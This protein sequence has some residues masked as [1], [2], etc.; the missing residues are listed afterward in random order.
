[1]DD[2][3]YER[4]SRQEQGYVVCAS[5]A[6]ATCFFAGLP[7]I[8]FGVVPR[9][10]TISLSGK[11]CTPTFS[12]SEADNS[13]SVGLLIP[14]TVARNVPTPSSCTLQDKARS[15]WSS[16]DKASSTF[17]T[18]P[19]LRLVRC[20]MARANSSVSMTPAYCTAGKQSS[21]CASVLRLRPLRGTMC[22]FDMQYLHGIYGH[23]GYRQSSLVTTS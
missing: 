5:S 12:T 20:D 7:T 10:C 18:S 22:K 23:G 15:R 11:Q 14:L 9:N 13:S 3:A 19:V 21:C 4:L 6:A 8:F 2:S 16:T 1:M 17:F